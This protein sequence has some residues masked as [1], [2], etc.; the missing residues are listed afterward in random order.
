MNDALFGKLAEWMGS[1]DFEKSKA[2]GVSKEIDLREFLNRFTV[3]HIASM[4]IE[5]YVTG[6]T[7]KNTFCYMVE[8]TFDCFGTIKG[9][10]SAYQKY[11]VYWNKK[12]GGYSFG[13]KRTKQRRGFGSTVEKIYENVRKE[14]IN[15]IKASR[16]GDY[17]SLAK[18]PLNP[19]FKNKISY[20]YNSEKEIPIYSANDLQIILKA[21]NIPFSLKENRVYLRKK[22]YEFYKDNRIDEYVNPYLF[23]CFLYNP[24]GYRGVLRPNEKTAESKEE[25]SPTLIDVVNLESAPLND[26]NGGGGKFKYDPSIEEK[27]KETGLKAENIV[28]QYLEEHKAEMNIKEI[29]CWCYGADQNDAKGYDFSYVTN[30]GEEI[31]IEVKG[32]RADLKDRVC[33][34]MSI[35]E[36]N[37]MKKNMDA[38]YVYFVNN[39]YKEKVIRRIPAREITGEKPV[40]F[41]LDFVSEME[42]R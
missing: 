37:V 5:E 6:R 15:A 33:F 7:F 27:R 21:L 42:G 24:L 4:P 38:Y 19:M 36:F 18:N 17:A 40:K 11:V 10:T 2:D 20:L 26:G 28:S 22:L 29:H 13:D 34:E 16:N 39:V 3:E 1:Q 30:D 12:S 14:I 41:R 23:M 9:R 8:E 31:L 32:T 25:T 35:N